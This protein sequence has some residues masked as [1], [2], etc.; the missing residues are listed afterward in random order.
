MDLR[1]LLCQ[2]LTQVCNAV[3]AVEGSPAMAG[4]D[5]AAKK[6]EAQ[7]AV[8]QFLDGLASAGLQFTRDHVEAVAGAA[9]DR[10]VGLANDLGA[11][12]HHPHTGL[13]GGTG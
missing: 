9:I 7:K 5:G 13:S 11:F 4:Q 10:V 8:A 12:V 1:Q 3:T 6:A 2:L